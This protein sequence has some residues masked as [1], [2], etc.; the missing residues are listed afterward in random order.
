[1]GNI[2][3]P[4]NQ[5]LSTEE[6]ETCLRD[7]MNQNNI[8][9]INAENRYLLKEAGIHY[10]IENMDLNEAEAE[11]LKKIISKRI[12][13]EE[14]KVTEMIP[15]YYLKDILKDLPD[16]VRKTDLAK[17]Y[18]NVTNLSFSNSKLRLKASLAPFNTLTDG[19]YIAVRQKG[20]KALLEIVFYSTDQQLKTILNTEE[21]LQKFNA[22]GGV[23]RNFLNKHPAVL[24]SRRN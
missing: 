17:M 14:A 5:E 1:M 6:I 13:L 16:N 8:K 19:P 23:I 12:C 15:A 9:E 2:D 4:K 21:R 22:G 24:G 10:V 3:K 20:I 7:W 18:V 11:E